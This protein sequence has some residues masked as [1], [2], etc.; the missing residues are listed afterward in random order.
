MS[1]ET[2]EL[3]QRAIDHWN[4]GD[5][6]AWAQD[7]TDDIVWYPILE[8]TQTEPVSGREAV[9]D[10]LRDW[11]APWRSYTI[12]AKRLVDEGD[13]FVMV[14]TQTGTD[15][16]GTEVTMEMHASGRVRDGRLAE[17]RWFQSEADAFAAA[18][19]SG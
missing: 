11:I 14:T 13:A 12:E 16:S 4:S 1:E 9:V 7:V 15:E 19:I 17:M 2:L 3:V 5:I 18:G 10:F 6:D 8:M